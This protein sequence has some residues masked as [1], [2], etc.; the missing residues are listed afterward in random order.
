MGG[1][2]LGGG[3]MPEDQSQIIV[4][5]FTFFTDSKQPC[6]RTTHPCRSANDR[7]QAPQARLRTASM[8]C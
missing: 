2:E 4:R 6:S 8:T 1:L 5:L 3:L 7:Y